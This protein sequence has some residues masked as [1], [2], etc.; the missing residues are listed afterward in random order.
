MGPYTRFFF[1]ITASDCVSSFLTTTR[2][3]RL[4]S[5]VFLVLTKNKLRLLFIQ[6]DNCVRLRILGRSFTQVN[7]LLV[8]RLE[9]DP[10]QTSFEIKR[11]F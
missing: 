11:T 7:S 9:I 5:L 6:G 8:V 1:A 4:S 3:L 2:L 10:K